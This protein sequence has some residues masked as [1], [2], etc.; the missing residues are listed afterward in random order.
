MN[1][2]D[3][4]MFWGKVVNP[5]TDEPSLRQS[6][7]RVGLSKTPLPVQEPHGHIP[8][9]NV[10]AL[11]TFSVPLH[12]V[13]NGVFSAGFAGLAPTASAYECRKLVLIVNHRCESACGGADR[14]CAGVE[15]RHG[16][17]QEGQGRQPPAGPAALPARCRHAPVRTPRLPGLRI[18]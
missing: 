18:N 12:R 6:Q 15:A 17:Q 5:N 9:S 3:I 14:P 10:S 4:R 13:R 8:D 16:P 2:D 7:R 1:T 11:S